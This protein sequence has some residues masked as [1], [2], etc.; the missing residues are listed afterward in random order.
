M[1]KFSLRM[2]ALALCLL[3][4][5]ISFSSCGY[6]V[7]SFLSEYSENKTK[8]NYD[9]DEET[10]R[11]DYLKDETTR[12][13]P[14]NTEPPSNRGTET[15]R[16]T[17]DQEPTTSR[18][19]STTRPVRPS[20]T[21]AA[22][23]TTSPVT[24]TPVTTDNIPNEFRN[25][26]YLENKNE[27]RCAELIGDVLVTVVLVSDKDSKWDSSSTAALKASLAN[28]EKTLESA[29]AKYGKELDITY[30]YITASYSGSISS[31]DYPDV[32]QNTTI[33]SLGFTSVYKAQEE[34]DLSND[35]DSN[36]IAF[37]LNKP[38]R[39]YAD[40]RS[41]LYD[42][43]RLTLFSSDISAFSHELCHLY[44]AAD[45]YFPASVE[46]LAGKYL[47][48][49]IM[50]RGSVID[51]VTAFIIGWD[52][53]LDPEAYS[54]LKDTAHLTR[55]Y[56]NSENDKQQTT[57]YV[58]DFKLS[59]GTYTGLLDRGVPMGKGTLK[60]NSGGVVTGNFVYGSPEGQVT[61]TW[62]SGDKYE[63][64]Y[65]NGDF[66]G[67]GTY[68]WSDGTV[69]S[70]NWVKGKIN[71]KG[72]YS[73]KNGNSY[74]GDFVDGK[75]TGKGRF[76]WAE[77]SYYE[78][79]FIN[80]IF[81]GQGTYVTTSGFVYVGAWKNNEQHGYGK[82]TYVDGSFYEGNF[83]KGSRTG[84]GVMK[85]SDGSSY[86]GYWLNNRRHG[87][88]KYINKYGTVFDGMWSNDVFQS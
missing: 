73:W 21:T 44:G 60:Y 12:R 67:F 16:D 78:G 80:N 43:E 30:S 4:V 29:A 68:T 35:A 18:P 40:S 57:G 75:R 54:F 51:P 71:G 19:E 26:V 17:Q 74:V 58:T 34:L 6:F 24:T 36:P 65:S 88:G 31:G 15:V 38:G 39:A 61:Y 87:N 62:P 5:S 32:W 66:N 50:S 22:P 56:L 23:E 48:E 42:T 47:P 81:E 37:M 9:Y 33:S 7:D 72:T 8:Y 69:Y 2:A 63:G 59:Y 20:L 27:G 11:E 14:L 25:H 10:D 3:T 70:G 84:Y 76:T 55:E 28:Q 52:E 64:N 85:W 82:A 1:K 46:E 86:D 53:E 83:D 79:D 13:G 77:G 41:S 49:S 45:F